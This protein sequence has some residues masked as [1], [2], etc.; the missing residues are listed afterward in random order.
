MKMHTEQS[1]HSRVHNSSLYRG[2][3]VGST[4][5][6]GCH[7]YS[8]QSL[9]VHWLALTQY[10]LYLENRRG[11]YCLCQTCFLF[12]HTHL[13]VCECCTYINSFASLDCQFCHM[14]ASDFCC[15][16]LSLVFLFCFGYFYRVHGLCCVAF[17]TSN[18][19]TTHP[20]PR[21]AFLF[22]HKHT[23]TPAEWD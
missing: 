7:I 20:T 2:C 13:L 14:W 15:P 10:H 11:R 1:G 23:Q 21:S 6:T 8:D 19:R 22:L 4:D 12:I 3:S 18:I 16:I 9:I 5:S 17:Q